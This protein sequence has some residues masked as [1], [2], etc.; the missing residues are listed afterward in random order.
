MLVGGRR[1]H[2]ALNTPIT[3]SAALPVASCPFQM[4]QEDYPEA[5]AKPI[6]KFIEFG[7]EDA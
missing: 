3:A 6:L 7:G 4:P 2:V 5:I 1:Q